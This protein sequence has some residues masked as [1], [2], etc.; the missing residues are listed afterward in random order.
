M[1]ESR[2]WE[3]DKTPVREGREKSTAQFSQHL[4]GCQGSFVC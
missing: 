1:W 4:V 3:W 2:E